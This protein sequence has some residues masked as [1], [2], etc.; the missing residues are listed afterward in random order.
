M[1]EK[2]ATLKDIA[3]CISAHLKRIEADPKLNKFKHS[4]PEQASGHFTPFWLARC[5]GS[6]RGV[7]ILYVGYQSP[8]TLTRRQAERYLAWLDAGNVGKH[9]Q[10]RD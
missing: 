3:A 5:W 7:G 6:G 2:H 10:V 8:T 1:S 4:T 9:W